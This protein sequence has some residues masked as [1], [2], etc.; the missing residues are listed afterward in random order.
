M[1]YDPWEDPDEEMEVLPDEMPP[2]MAKK[3][4]PKGADPEDFI[5]YMEECVSG[6]LPCVLCLKGSSTYFTNEQVKAGDVPWYKCGH[7]FIYGPLTPMKQVITSKL[8]IAQ[9]AAKK[10]KAAW[11]DPAAAL[12]PEFT[13]EEATKATFKMLK[14]IMDDHSASSESITS[15]GGHSIPT[16]SF[17][18]VDFLNLA[19]SIGPDDESFLDPQW[20]H[21]N[22]SGCD[23]CSKHALHHGL[24][25]EKHNKNGIQTSIWQQC[26]NKF[27]DEDA[28]GMHITFHNLMA[29][30]AH[31]TLGGTNT[32][33]DEILEQMTTVSMGEMMEKEYDDYMSTNKPVYKI[34]QKA[35]ANR[36]MKS[37]KQFDQQW[38]DEDDSPSNPQYINMMRTDWYKLR[39]FLTVLVHDTTKKE[40]ATIIPDNI[41]RLLDLGPGDN[42]FIPV[43]DGEDHIE[44]DVVE[45]A[46][47]LCNDYK[48]RSGKKEAWNKRVVNDLTYLIARV[49][50]EAIDHFFTNNDNLGP[51]HTVNYTGD[52]RGVMNRVLNNSVSGYLMQNIFV[53]AYLTY[54]GGTEDSQPLREATTDPLSQKARGI[55]AIST[56][57]GGR[58]IFQPCP[59]LHIALETALRSTI[60][61]LQLSIARAFHPDTARKVLSK[62]LYLRPCPQHP[63]PGVLPNVL[64][65]TVKQFAD[66]VEMLAR[67][68]LDPDHDDYD[69][70]GC[71]IVQRYIKPVCS[72]VMVRGGNSF[73]I[74]PS[75]DGVTAGGGT[76]IIF[77][78]NPMGQ[79]SVDRVVRDLR[80]D[81]G[82][83]HH[84]IE[85]VYE[86]P[87]S[88]MATKK[89]ITHYKKVADQRH[90]GESMR[91]YPT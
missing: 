45:Y 43:E 80:L 61:D 15:I 11:D 57:T 60:G 25:H 8:K 32:T 48:R 69:P 18:V 90:H 81:D 35:R 89:T 21:C 86:Q 14:K 24:Y 44:T 22:D 9:K 27:G 4:L 49:A 41:E 91:K 29:W 3:A 76:N 74:G 71:L 2:G 87:G 47:V 37:V 42:R 6:D 53:M 64:A 75:N 28:D 67:C 46:L 30:W 34:V 13:D 20:D 40:R 36:I 23:H 56:R 85:F 50:D 58:G 78:L 1:S 68:M 79:R 31:Q 55:Q 7:A 54:D 10:A 88:S 5:K 33:E 66:G 39:D 77:T 51:V 84:E 63:R 83:E 72:G 59:A 19:A 26:I 70:Q 16:L 62:G 65:T 17:D 82:M 73:I 38:F 52:A 12:P